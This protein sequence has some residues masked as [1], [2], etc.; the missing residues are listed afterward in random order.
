[1]NAI[2]P[3]ASFVLNIGSRKYPLNKLL[4]TNFENKYKIKKMKISMGGKAGALGKKGEGETFY[5]I[6]K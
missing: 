1:M 3:G 5:S 4:F 2:K 6:T